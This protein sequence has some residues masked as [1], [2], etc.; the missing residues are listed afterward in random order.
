MSVDPSMISFGKAEPKE[1]HVVALVK[2]KFDPCAD[3]KASGN[4][5]DVILG[6]L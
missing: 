6:L 2:N 1:G 4:I 5:R 3:A